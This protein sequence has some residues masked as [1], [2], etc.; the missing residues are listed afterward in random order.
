[1]AKLWIAKKATEGQ[2][3]RSP[4]EKGGNTSETDFRWTSGFKDTAI[5]RGE[6]Y[7]PWIPPPNKE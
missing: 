5:K 1:M 7:D 6:I 2:T 3:E 4:F